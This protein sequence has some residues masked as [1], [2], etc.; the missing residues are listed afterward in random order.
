MFLVGAF[1]KKRVD[2]S[3]VMAFRQCLFFDTPEVTKMILPKLL[4]NL[5]LYLLAQGP[6][7]KGFS[8]FSA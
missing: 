5:K 6:K 4:Q 3:Q 2:Y 8:F 7:P 1:L